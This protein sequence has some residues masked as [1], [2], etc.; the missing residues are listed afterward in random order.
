M[1]RTRKADKVEQ[2]DTEETAEGAGT[3]SMED[4]QVTGN[5]G[6][7]DDPGINKSTET[8]LQ[9]EGAEG[10]HEGPSGQKER[11]DMSQIGEPST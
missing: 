2:G 10:P 7:N 11:V 6:E 3:S 5:D 9:Q 1:P 8:Q 4:Q